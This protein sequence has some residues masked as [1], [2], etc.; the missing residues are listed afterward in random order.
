MAALEAHTRPFDYRALDRDGATRSGVLQATDEGAAA[1]QLIEQGLTPLSL[2]GARGASTPG[3][4]RRGA[5]ASIGAADRIALVQE[6]ATLL[7]A[8][9][10]LGE[11]LPSLAETY[12]AQSVGPA[13][14]GVERAVRAGQTLSSA[15]AAS[16][17]GLPAYVLALTEAGEASGELAG[18]LRDA[19][20]QMDHERR[21]TQEL[22]SA[23]IYPSVLVGAGVLAVGVIFIG[24]VPRFAGILKS[25]RAEVPALSR[26]VIEAGLFVKEHLAAF[27]FGA[28]ALA[29][30]LAALLTRPA[31]RA[32]L[33]DGLARL[34]VIGP[35]LHSVDLG[36]WATVF[37]QLLANRVPLIDAVKLS[38][39]ALR[40]TR[41]RQDLAR[42]PRELE[43]GR[44]LSE[45]LAGMSWFPANRLN[46]VKVG[47][48]SGELP[49]ML[50][51]L[52]SV[53]TE[54]ARVL[55]KRAL[56]L[57]EPA[58][59]LVIGAV[60][61]VVMVAVMMAITSLNTVA[62]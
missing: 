6:L 14:A 47:E 17:L 29:L 44:A 58:A 38:T 62:L 3:A 23:L 34:P 33:F 13:L 39:G 12:A 19:A 54:A 31:M 37:G 9:V 60:I 59:I 52:G 55:Q 41:L 42:A 56:A 27:G 32:A 26:A 15:L 35:W 22:K 4:G 30:L 20:A 18:A 46:L 24:V 1:R 45:I 11:A 53:E 2:Q 7:G 36:R 28:A 16:P 40:L 10:S 5:A 49:R 57:I 50:G 43:R 21:T 61:G 25:S 48:R 8:G 51:M